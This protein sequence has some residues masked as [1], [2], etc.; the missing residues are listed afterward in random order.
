MIGELQRIATITTSTA[1]LDAGPY[2]SHEGW[3][4][5]GDA[6]LF[7]TAETYAVNGST[8]PLNNGYFASPG[9]EHSGTANFG[10]A[11]GSF[12]RLTIPSTL[13]CSHS[14]GAWLMAIRPN[15]ICSCRSPGGCGDGLDYY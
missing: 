3:A 13:T 12:A 8:L 14:W 4:V 6:T 1:K 11:D 10:L 7:T 5:G 15:P 2:L 9:S